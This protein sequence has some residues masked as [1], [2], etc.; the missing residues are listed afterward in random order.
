MYAAAQ[1]SHQHPLLQ[2]QGG[3]S[4]GVHNSPFKSIARLCAR[5]K[6][7]CNDLKRFKLE[8]EHRP[9]L[10]AE[11]PSMAE[12]GGGTLSSPTTLAVIALLP[13]LSH[14]FGYISE[15]LAAMQAIIA[16]SRP[17]GG[18]RGSVAGAKRSSFTAP[19]FRTALTGGAAGSGPALGSFLPQRRV[20]GPGC[21]RRPVAVL[22]AHLKSAGRRRAPPAAS[23][24]PLP[25]ACPSAA[26]QAAARQRRRQRAALPAPSWRRATCLAAWRASSSPMPMQQVGGW[27]AR[28]LTTSIGVWVVGCAAPAHPLTRLGRLG[29]L[30]SPLPADWLA[31]H[32]HMLS[33]LKAEFGAVLFALCPLLLPTAFCLLTGPTLLARP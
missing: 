32:R 13:T 28:S 9:R 8:P 14:S 31:L 17:A 2:L 29:R 10:G 1:L 18:L 26:A 4:T 21:L 6:G 20:G 12:Q 33:L 25:A 22:Q 30:P 5:R 7:G 11:H 15:G 3:P 24:S 23:H 27:V 19:A 16:H